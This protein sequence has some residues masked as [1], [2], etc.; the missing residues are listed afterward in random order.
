MHKKIFILVVLIGSLVAATAGLIIGHRNQL[1]KKAEVASAQ[2]F[3]Y[4][5]AKDGLKLE[6]DIPFDGK[7]FVPD[8]VEFLK[9]GEPYVGGDVIRQRVKELNANLGQ[10]HAEYLLDHQDLI[11]KE[12]RGK[13]YLTFPGT[14]WQDS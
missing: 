9:P 1:L 3:K 8:I 4:D 12:W 6:E 5:Q 11:L 10:H 7:P 14:V 13:Y 2:P